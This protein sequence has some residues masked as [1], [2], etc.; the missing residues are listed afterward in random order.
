MCQNS[1]SDKDA[2]SQSGEDCAGLREIKNKKIERE[3]QTDRQKRENGRENEKFEEE[4]ESLLFQII[5]EKGLELSLYTDRAW[6]QLE[7]IQKCNSVETNRLTATPYLRAIL[8][9]PP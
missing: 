2:A 1:N 4:N 6:R 9:L 3:R 5:T 7:Q 8:I